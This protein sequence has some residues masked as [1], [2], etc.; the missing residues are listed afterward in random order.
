MDPKKLSKIRQR[1][2]ETPKGKRVP[3]N[4]LYPNG[5]ERDYHRDLNKLVYNLSD[6]INEFLVPAI[7]SMI[8]EVE[9]K[10]PMDRNDDFLSRLNQIILF[11]RK[12]IEPDVIKTIAE[13]E[14]VGFQIN[15]FNNA[16]FQKTTESVFGIDMFMN[17][18]WL[19]D[20][21]KLFASQN[22]QLITSLPDE[23]L[24]RVSGIVERG[25]QEGKQYKEVAKEIKKSFGIT[26]RR[27]KLIARDQTK[28]LNS[29]LTRLRQQELGVEEYIWQTV[30]DGRVRETHQANDG[31]KF[32]W[33]TPPKITGHPGN[34]VNCRCIARPVLDHLLF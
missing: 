15:S 29:S 22:S 21:L 12:A 27:A 19:Q 6:L 14:Q 17:E 10:T 4:W 24:E 34:D 23:E 28:K 32:R 25:L 11:I 13:A 5:I 18:P 3:P 7:P 26:A 16:Q 1:K 33:D 30:Q 8:L 31:K 2:L 9:I 20:Q